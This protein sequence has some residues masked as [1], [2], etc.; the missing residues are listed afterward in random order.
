MNSTR[1]KPPRGQ[2][3]G[4]RMVPGEKA[5]D[6]RKTSRRFLNYLGS[7]KI[8]IVIVMFFALLSTVFMIIGPKVLGNATTLLAE[9]LI[10]QYTGTGSGIDFEGIAQILLWLLGIYIVSSFF[11]FIQ[12]M[13]MTGIS[14]K[15]TYRLRRD[16]SEK[17]NR[18]PINFRG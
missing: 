10:G 11:S 17:L 4:A 2:G 18:L 3:M 12:G 8:G 13:I 5:K 1:R 14:M 7:Y 15:I 9:G 16:I 6:F